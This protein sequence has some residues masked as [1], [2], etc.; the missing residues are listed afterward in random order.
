MAT[1]I[2]PRVCARFDRF[3]VDLSSGEL[4]RSGVRVPIQEQPL[5]VLRLL[6]EAEGKVVTRED[7]RAALWPK[8]TFVDFEHGV[9]TAVKKLRQAL[10]DSAERP[11]F[12]ETLPKFGYRFISPVEWET[13]PQPPRKRRIAEWALTIVGAALLT[14]VV[15]AVRYRSRTSE[16]HSEQI[17]SIA[18]LPLANL[19]G[20]TTQD[21]F[22]DGMTET[23]ITDLA[24][25]G[26]LRVISRTSAM[27]YKNTAKALPE[28]AQELGV[29]AVIE[30]AVL[31][32]GNHVRI[33][34]QLLR[35]R[36]DQHLWAQA[37]ERDLHDVLSLQAEVA[38]DIAQQVQ[39]AITPEESARL[40]KAHTTV[41]AA[42]EA[43][44]K[45]QFA[46]NQATLESTRSAIRF[47]RDA[48]RL[49]P[50]YA[51]A[52]ACL[53]DSYD[54]LEYMGEVPDPSITAE[55]QKAVET[56]L[57]LDPNLAEA[58][59]TL[60]RFYLLAWKWSDAEGQFRRAIKLNPNYVPA[61]VGYAMYL[62]L[63][64]QADQAVSEAQRAWELDPVSSI[65]NQ[66][67]T[68][69][70]FLARQ[71]ERA[72]KQ[73][74]TSV[75]LSPGSADAHILLSAAYHGGGME[76]QGFSEWFESMQLDGDGKLADQ[77]RR[78]VAETPA[79]EARTMTVGK[80]AVKYLLEKSKHQYVS[81]V[82]IARMLVDSGNRDKA[83]FWL[84][85]A[86]TQHDF[87]L[88]WMNIDPS[89]DGLRSDARFQ[90]LLRKIGLLN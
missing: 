90:A 40:A 46:F 5:Q 44:L 83:F 76:E 30:G 6:L 25:I 81:P 72:I 42:Y 32:S 18:V 23:L 62:D 84:D 68:Y 87:A 24:Q 35:V 86:C 34:A 64:R 53:A 37:Y 38:R 80:E 3:Q 41:P 21:Y 55:R 47:F 48:I 36:T 85:K 71:Y 50:N 58:H 27:H 60:A 73:G 63:T 54:Q 17:K 10:E 57:V 88:P 8:D 7:L 13:Q 14:L 74:R 20:D 89:F 51:A 61:H 9:N 31:R 19:S 2:S 11:E 16:R 82:N 70:Y 52:Y 26:S 28:I 66:Q 12:V 43:Y 78:V 45:G 56:S 77:L 69:T 59:A 22:A 79:G 15:G 49:D 67:L 4:L 29:D 1:Y 65:T 33:T 75:D 39:A